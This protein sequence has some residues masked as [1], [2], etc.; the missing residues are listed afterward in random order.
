[1]PRSQA[2]VLA[3]ARSRYN[4]DWI[5]LA[6]LGMGMDLRDLTRLTFSPRRQDL[7]ILLI[8]N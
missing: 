8:D 2:S 5:N 4:M 1:M 3:R 6:Q 7:F